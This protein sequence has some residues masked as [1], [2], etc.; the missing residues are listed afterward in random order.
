MQSQYCAYVQDALSRAKNVRDVVIWNETNSALFWKPQ[1]GAAAAY[2]SLLAT[3]Y[4]PL[5]KYLKQINIISSSIAARE[6]GIH[7]AQLGAASRKQ[8][9][10]RSVLAPF[11]HGAHVSAVSTESPLASHLGT[12]SFYRG[13]YVRR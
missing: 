6:R 7:R 10:A 8:M 12:L 11:G 1:Q 9:D 3:C 13:D 2:E 4:D 5:L